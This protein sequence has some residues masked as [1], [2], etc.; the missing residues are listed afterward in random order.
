[1]DYSFIITDVGYFVTLQ[2]DNGGYPCLFETTEH[3][4]LFTTS[5]KAYNRRLEQEYMELF[6]TADGIKT[7][8]WMWPYDEPEL[9]NESIEL[10][11]FESVQACI[12]TH[13]TNCLSYES[14]SDG[15]VKFE[16]TAL[17]LALGLVQRKDDAAHFYLAP[18]WIM[19]V[20]RTSENNGI[21]ESY[22]SYLH[23]NAVDGTLL[24]YD[25]MEDGL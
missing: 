14:G 12:R 16:A 9:V 10:L 6:I 4:D 22:T 11:P 1:M 13:L 18:V 24:S 17:T 25:G 15:E 21:S 23:V 5:D 2:R 7:C 19:A 20:N 3:T 8:I